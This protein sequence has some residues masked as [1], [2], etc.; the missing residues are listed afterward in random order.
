[1]LEGLR[2]EMLEQITANTSPFFSVDIGSF[3]YTIVIEKTGTTWLNSPVIAAFLGFMLGFA[4][5]R[6]NEHFKE[7]K[8]IDRYEYFVLSK[9]K[10]I[11]D[12]SKINEKNVENFIFKL[13]MDLRFSKLKSSELVISLFK[14]AKNNESY[15]DELTKINLR[16]KKLRKGGII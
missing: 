2:Y 9:A 4:A 12:S 16:L 11:V 3:I 5:N 8:E 1:L 13:Y 15:Q 10:D 14:K 6:L 7:K